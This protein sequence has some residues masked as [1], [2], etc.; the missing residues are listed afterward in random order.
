MARPRDNAD[1]FSGGKTIEIESGIDAGLTVVD[2]TGRQILKIKES[3]E[4]Y[5]DH[6]GGSDI[7]NGVILVSDGGGVRVNDLGTLE[8]T[9][10]GG[11][12]WF[13]CCDMN[14][15][16][17]DQLPPGQFPPSQSNDPCGSTPLK[18]E[19]AYNASLL[20]SASG[21]I[22]SLHLDSGVGSSAN[23]SA[24]IDKNGK[25]FTCGSTKSVRRAY[26][27]T[28]PKNDKPTTNF[29]DVAVPLTDY[30]NS[31][32]S[33]FKDKFSEINLTGSLPSGYKAKMVRQSGG[34]T[35][36]LTEDKKIWSIG[37]EYRGNRGVD[38]TSSY[39]YTGEGS[40]Q[41]WEK[42]TLN[43]DW[44]YFSFGAACAFAIADDG[45]LWGTGQNN[46]LYTSGIN[47]KVFN[48]FGNDTDWKM[49]S[50]A[51]DGGIVFGLKTN[52][53][54]YSW[55][56]LG[57]SLGR[58]APTT[59][60]SQSIDQVGI[61]SDWIYVSAS[62]LNER[63]HNSHHFLALKSDGTLW[64]FG[65]EGSGF[66]TYSRSNSLESGSGGPNLSVDEDSPNEEPCIRQLGYES[67]WVFCETCNGKSVALKCDGSLWSTGINGFFELGIGGADRDKYGRSTP[68][69]FRDYAYATYILGNFGGYLSSISSFVEEI[70]KRRKWLTIAVANN[71]VLAFDTD[72]VLYG[73]GNNKT[74][75]DTHRNYDGYTEISDVIYGTNLGL[76]VA[77]QDR[78]TPCVFGDTTY[79]SGSGT[80]P[81]EPPKVKT[82]VAPRYPCTYVSP[83]WRYSAKADLWPAH[84][85]P[86]PVKQADCVKAG[87]ATAPVYVY[88]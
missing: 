65:E 12:T 75:Q 70:T 37:R 88:K 46:P 3:G 15:I 35:I 25:L 42:E 48:K 55:G 50:V 21:G 51:N 78:F 64:G 36:I 43:K 86:D 68:G 38:Y 33:G 52:G 71:H 30:Y 41:I 63:Y 83:G 61:D 34:L 73:A 39:G 29:N 5:Q 20:I 4:I 9:D 57:G 60:H 54:L 69:K 13:T 18:F 10:D 72:F 58:Y 85:G 2:K 11:R 17:P 26:Q 76:T 79:D 80:P 24:V 8:I 31:N 40:S 84:V 16:P 7:E 45:T 6:D 62:G 19:D 82:L 56:K 27:D 67:D 22:N 23:V 77:S 66:H 14:A 53:K 1:I 44:K 59:S 74:Y 81:V 32:N 47:Y 49:V 28:N 87:Q